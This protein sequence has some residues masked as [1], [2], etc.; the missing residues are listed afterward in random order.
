MASLAFVKTAAP[1][2]YHPHP[3][4]TPVFSFDFSSATLKTDGHINSYLKYQAH[5][6]QFVKENCYVVLNAK[7]VYP[8]GF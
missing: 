7:E 3:P 5:P 6:A 1:S 2:K 4:S 8:I